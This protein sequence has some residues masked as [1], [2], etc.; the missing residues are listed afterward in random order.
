MQGNMTRVIAAA[1]AVAVTVGLGILS[2]SPANAG[3][4]AD[5]DV[6]ALVLSNITT[7]SPTTMSVTST[8]RA[9]YDASPAVFV[10]TTEV[11]GLG[12]AQDA[13]CTLFFNGVAQSEGACWTLV[14]FGNSELSATGNYALVT[15]S[16]TLASWTFTNPNT[17]P[18]ALGP[19]VCKIS[20]ITYTAPTKT[21]TKIT[22]KT[23]GKCKRGE[24]TAWSD[25]G[26]YGFGAKSKSTFSFK[27]PYLTNTEV[28]TKLQ[29]IFTPED[30]LKTT[31][32]SVK[33]R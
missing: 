18:P 8:R 31:N 6:S 15:G 29:L 11:N 10:Y 27:H 14:G 23:N 5:Q 3:S 16:Q 26:T 1:G 22:V 28:P 2:S 9:D 24:W 17:A 25:P 19:A 33:I 21:G 32:K 7:I 4:R 13:T 30:D 12:A 20:K